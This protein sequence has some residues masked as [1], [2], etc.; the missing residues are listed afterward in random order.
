MLGF[1]RIITYKCIYKYSFDYA[2][3]QFPHST[4]YSLQRCSSLNQKCPP[5]A[6]DLNNMFSRHFSREIWMM[7]SSCSI[8]QCR[9]VL[10]FIYLHLTSGPP[11]CLAGEDGN[12]SFLFTSCAFS[13]APHHD[14]LWSPWNHRPK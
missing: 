5:Q 14:R 11:S 3:P 6:V 8:H 2:F 13:H 1:M 7:E 4:F 12:I 9:S 10:A